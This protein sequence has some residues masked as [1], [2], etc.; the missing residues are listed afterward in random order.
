[1]GTITSKLG[2]VKPYESDYFNISDFNANMDKID[3]LVH[4]VES[5]IVTSNRTSVG[6]ENLNAGTVDWY[7][8]KYNDGTLEACGKWKVTNWR[9]KDK[10]G[11]DGTWR[12]GYIRVYYPNIGQK[13]I[14]Y[15]NA[16]V[17]ASSGSGDSITNWIMDCSAYGE[18]TSYQ[19]LRLVAPKIEGEDKAAVEKV[20]YMEF[21]GTWK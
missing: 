2:L 15:K 9:C 4:I 3:N 17:A 1:M 19:S 14:F 5:G 6:A 13:S 11:E 21:K 7:Y 8:K 16:M 12:S 18:D 10:Q 20:I